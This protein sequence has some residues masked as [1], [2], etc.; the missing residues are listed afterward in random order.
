[1]TA[2]SAAVSKD[3]PPVFNNVLA[4]SD[5]VTPYIQ[6]LT[7]SCH[8]HGCAVMIQLTHLSRRTN[9]NK[10]NWLPS[11]SSSKHREPA[12]RAFPK[13]IEDWDIERIINVFA[14]ASE[15]MQAGGM[16]GLELQVY[17]HWRS[18]QSTTV[19]NRTERQACRFLLGHDNRRYQTCRAYTYVSNWLCRQCSKHSCSYLRFSA[20][21]KGSVKQIL[22]GCP[23]TD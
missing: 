1:M 5:D 10:G 8:E 18:T 16:D 2:G 15:R 6:N 23:R 14:D 4:Y 3:S 22:G 20:L 19:R 9:C 17:G 12:H 11:V 13:L 21:S 7:D